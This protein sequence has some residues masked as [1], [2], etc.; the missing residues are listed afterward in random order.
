MDKPSDILK[1]HIKALKTNEKIRFDADIVRDTGVNKGVLS[2][3]ISGK[4][5]PSKNFIKKF[6]E[7][8][9]LS[10]KKDYVP[11]TDVKLDDINLTPG[12]NKNAKKKSLILK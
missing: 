9:K 4:E 8:Y 5:E 12:E 1:F 6:E 2:T 11:P 3:Y 10:F 7:V